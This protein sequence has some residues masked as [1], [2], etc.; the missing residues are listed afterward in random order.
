MNFHDIHEAYMNPR[1]HRATLEYLVPCLSCLMIHACIT[2]TE[3]HW[4]KRTC[5][6]HVSI[7][8]VL[9]CIGIGWHSYGV[10]KTVNNTVGF[11][12]RVL[13]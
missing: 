1:I 7:F 8:R 6:I 2:P 4:M 10:P 13:G 5:S 12:S 9:E 11:G 3:M